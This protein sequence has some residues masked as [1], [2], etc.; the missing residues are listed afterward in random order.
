MVSSMKTFLFIFLG[1]QAWTFAFACLGPHGSLAPH[2]L[3][4]PGGKRSFWRVSRLHASPRGE[5]PGWRGGGGSGLV[6]AP[7]ATLQAWK[8]QQLTQQGGQQRCRQ[9]VG[10]G[11]AFLKFMTPIL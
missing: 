2:D 7:V 5:V 9:H 6:P 1:K 8:Y 10:I 11:S 3:G 4:S